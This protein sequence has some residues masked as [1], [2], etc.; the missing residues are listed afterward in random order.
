MKKMHIGGVLQMLG[1]L[2]AQQGRY[3]EAPWRP[4][5][6]H[7]RDDHVMTGDDHARIAAAIERRARRAAKRYENHLACKANYYRGASL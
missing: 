5:G 6:G 1:M 4:T 2:S 7:R 3:G